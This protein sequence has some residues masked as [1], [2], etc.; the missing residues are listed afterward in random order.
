MKPIATLV[1]LCVLATLV[2][3]PSSTA[4]IYQ[5]KKPDEPLILA[6]DLIL[7]DAQVVSKK[8]HLAVSGLTKDDFVLFEDSIRQQVSYFSQDALPLSILLLLDVSSSIAPNFPGLQ[9]AA[10]TALDS[11]KPTDEVAL[12]VFGGSAMVFQD[13]TRDKERVATAIA[14][15]DA[16]GLRQ[17][18]DVSEGAYAAASHLEKASASGSRRIIIA[19]TDDQTSQNIKTPR[20]DGTTLRKLHETK[21]TVCGLLFRPPYKRVGAEGFI[22]N[23]AEATGGVIASA[24]SKKLQANLEE[25]IR[26]L[27]TRY[28]LGYVSK[29]ENRDG[30][31]RKIKLG[32]SEEA[33]ERSGAME[34]LTRKGYYAAAPAIDKSMKAKKP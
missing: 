20:P 13:F 7:L 2:V 19:I 10:S 16:T 29:N 12:M 14:L 9:R 17:G 33:I 31:F 32:A 15:A 4:A 24:E 21:T 3:W 22:R 11:L 25:M 5:D 27:R 28:S 26:H 1:I 34:I 23:F 6:T 30:T 8:T 18:T